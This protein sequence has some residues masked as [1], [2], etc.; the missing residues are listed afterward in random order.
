[1]QEL[2]VLR[3]ERE[4]NQEIY[5]FRKTEKIYWQQGQDWKQILDNKYPVRFSVNLSDSVMKQK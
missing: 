1:M 3:A 4:G 5:K 2:S